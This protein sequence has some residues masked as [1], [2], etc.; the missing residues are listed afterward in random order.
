MDDYLANKNVDLVVTHDPQPLLIGCC[1]LSLKVPRILRLHI[2]LSSPNQNIIE[3]LK[4]FIEVFEKIIVSR[5]DYI[6]LWV[7]KNRAVTIM[8]AID[9][10]SAKNIR[11]P[12]INA[13][14]ILNRYGIKSGSPL[15]SQVSRFDAFKDPIGVIES[16]RL[17][18]KN[19]S[20]LQL[21]L[22]GI[23]EAPDDPQQQNYVKE[24][25]EYVDK[26]SGLF[27]FSDVK[28]LCGIANDEF[29]NA[30]QTASDVILQK[31]LQE[32]FGLTVSEAM[33][34]EKAVIGGNV[35]GI[36]LQIKNGKNGY[37]VNNFQEA[38][39]L[40][41]KL[42][43]DNQLRSRIG[44]KAKE[45]VREKFLMPRYIL[46]NLKIYDELLNS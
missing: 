21:I 15:I 12:K 38:A 44:K 32:G 41:V 42:L 30:V 4:P 43:K 13:W 28:D 24:V 39:K 14:K 33:W 17:A 23:I 18:K 46:E 3:F 34:K 19:I 6:P 10:L 7:K 11:L 29:I 36:K 37:L 35:G 20:D 25:K 31:S 45:T 8:P 40:I 2:D 5:E 16:Y 26:E 22:A 27:V 9:P 1:N